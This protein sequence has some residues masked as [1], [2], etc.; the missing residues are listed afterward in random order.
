MELASWLIFKLYYS[1]YIVLF[2]LSCNYKIFYIYM[3][4]EPKNLRSD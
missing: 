4:I 3:S 1:Y 2:F